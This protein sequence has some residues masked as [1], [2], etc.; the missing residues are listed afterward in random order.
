MTP[1]SGLHSEVRRWRV[2]RQRMQNLEEIVELIF[3]QLAHD[4][5]LEIVWRQRR[6]APIDQVAVVLDGCI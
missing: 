3:R 5:D 4:R 6:L 2:V 1:G